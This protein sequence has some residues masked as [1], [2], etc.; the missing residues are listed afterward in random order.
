MSTLKFLIPKTH[1][2]MMETLDITKICTTCN[3]FG[4]SY[5]WN[6]ITVACFSMHMS[7]S[8]SVNVI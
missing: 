2:N 6:A 7:T 4:M 8:Y 3:M 1:R 5:V